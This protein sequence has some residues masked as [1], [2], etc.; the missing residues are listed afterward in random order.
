[1]KRADG[2]GPGGRRSLALWIVAGLA[3]AC[4]EST[5]PRVAPPAPVDVVARPLSPHAVEL[6]WAMPA[7]ATAESFR[8]DRATMGQAYISLETVPGDER[9][10]EDTTLA[11]GVTYLYRLAACNGDLCSEYVSAE[12]VRT[13][14]VLAI[15]TDSLPFGVVGQP[16][17]AAVHATGGDGEYDWAVTAGSLPEGV[18]LSETVS[19]T[20]GSTDALVSGMPQTPGTASFTVT[21]ESGDGQTADAALSMVVYPA[22]APVSVETDVVPPVMAGGEYD[23]QLTGSGGVGTGVF[24]WSL[25]G[26]SLPP[27][28]T[29][30]SDGRI[31][32]TASS[33]GSYAFTVRAASNGESAEASFTLVVVP[34]RTTSY[35]IT[36]YPVVAIP[37]NIQP[38]VDSAIARWESALTSDLP[39]VFIKPGYFTPDDC[40]GFGD[41]A[42]GT[43][44]EDVLILIDIAPIDGPGGTLGEAGPCALRDQSQL[45]SVGTLTL[46]IADLEPLVGTN[47]LVALIEHEMAHI[48]GFGTLWAQF[49]LVQGAGTNDPVYTGAYAVAQWHLLGGSG[50]IPVANTGGEG[51]RDVHW[52]ESVFGNELMTGYIAK[53]GVPDPLSRMTIASFEDLGYSV[54]LDAADPYTLPTTTAASVADEAP[55][56][57]GRDVLYRGPVLVIGED[58]S[59]R[60]IHLP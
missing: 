36:P 32:G 3:A 18:V 37:A 7:G 44:V 42:N 54:N 31:R 48:I 12:P 21:V 26:G 9:T 35:D 58:G 27:G 40:G 24:T 43:T 51:T 11:P 59:V 41:A 16:Y 47:T 4:S 23:V 15:T 5:G 34:N 8:I 1:M 14:T 2:R 50:Y 25:V 46:D 29:L 22:A 13:Y 10:I 55:A 49:D 20:T 53:V 45:P 39:P 30:G 56:Y 33:P 60:R 19:P 17:S 38:A 57:L 52:R 6:S 28:L